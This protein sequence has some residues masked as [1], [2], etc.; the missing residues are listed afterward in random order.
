MSDETSGGDSGQPVG[1]ETSDSGS[2]ATGHNPG[3]VQDMG[4][5]QQPGGTWE[6]GSMDTLSIREGPGWGGNRPPKGKREG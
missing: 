6:P 1:S 4:G 2:G 3:G 5:G